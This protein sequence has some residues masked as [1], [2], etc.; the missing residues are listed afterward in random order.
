VYVL[1]PGAYRDPAEAEV[2]RAKL[3]RLGVEAVVQRIAIDA[4][5]FHRVRIGPISDLEALNRTR[6]RLRAADINAVVIRVGD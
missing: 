3:A 6:A 2:L 4:D 5:V 1:Q